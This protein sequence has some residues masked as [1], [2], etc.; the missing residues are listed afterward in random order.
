ME[1]CREFRTRPGGDRGGRP[2]GGECA[3]RY[4]AG[5][6]SVKPYQPVQHRKAN[7]ILMAPDRN[8]K[9]AQEAVVRRKRTK[10]GPAHVTY[11][12]AAREVGDSLRQ[13]AKTLGV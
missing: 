1:W 11:A 12:L 9:S 4:R 5:R 2:Q 6:L 8:A 13:I 10:I 7:H 3:I